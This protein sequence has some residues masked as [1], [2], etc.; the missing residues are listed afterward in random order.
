SLWSH[1]LGRALEG[2]MKGTKLKA[3]PSLHVTWAEWK[4][5][6]P[7]SVVLSK[8]KSPRRYY[9]FDPYADY[10][11]SPA[12]GIL[13]TVALDKRLHPKEFIL[14]VEL[15]GEAKA[16]PFSV[17]SQEKVVNDLLGDV[18]LVVAFRPE[19]AS[20]AVFDRRLEGRTLSFLPQP[21]DENLMADRETE[22]IWGRL[23]GKALEGP[24]KGKALRQVP[25]TSSFWFGWR[26][27]YPGTAIFKLK[28]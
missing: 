11:A 27:Y 3:L 7:K 18:P 12:T 23:T 17:L 5:L 19:S 20:G 16:Y 25:A 28:P 6:Y 26:D 13:P 9:S 24:L 10:Y 2:P 14:G 15:E 22:S 1:L 4:A 21:N 8:P